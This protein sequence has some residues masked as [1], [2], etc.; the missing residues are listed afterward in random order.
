MASKNYSEEKDIAIKIVN[1]FVDDFNIKFTG[2]YLRSKIK[3]GKVTDNRIFLLYSLE[4]GDEYQ[5]KL[6]NFQDFTV[7]TVYQVSR[8]LKELENYLKKEVQLRLIQFIKEN[9]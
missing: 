1:K 4:Y 7:N 2:F 6:L 5:P 3:R 9:T 8:D